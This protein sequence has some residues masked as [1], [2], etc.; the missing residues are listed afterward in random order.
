MT[1]SLG[2]APCHAHTVLAGMGIPVTCECDIATAVTMLIQRQFTDDVIFLEY[3]TQDF[4]RGIGMCSH[5]GQGDLRL[6]SGEICVK[7]HPCYPAKQGR[8]IAYEYVTRP[9]PATMACMT[10][11]GGG[12]RM[13]AAR[14]ECLAHER[15][16]SS[17]IQLYFKFPNREFNDAFRQWCDLGGIHHFGVAFGDHW[18]G[19]KAACRYLGVEFRGVE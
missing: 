1:D 16:P 5:C 6:A 17:T 19:L 18:E 15:V 13:I 12:W 9:G 2:I 8:G 4:A 11:L 10:Y 14:M 7:P 3:Y